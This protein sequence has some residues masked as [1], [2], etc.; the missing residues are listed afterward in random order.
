MISAIER[1]CER[2]RF[3]SLFPDILNEDR[4]VD[5][6]ECFQT[7]EGHSGCVNTLRW[8][9]T[10]TILASGSDDRTVKLWRA[11]EEKHSLDTGHEGNVFAVEFLPSS[12]DRK[13]V[14][15]AADHVVFLHDIETNTNRKW[16]VEGRV[17]RIC[18]LEHDPT[19]WW[20][21]VED[22]KG[23]HQFDTRLEEPEAIIQGPETNG[24]VRDVKSVAVSEAKPHLI[25]VGFD[26][27]AV[28][29]YDRRNFEAPVLTFNPLYTSPLDYHATHVAFNK[30]GTEVVVNHGCGGGVYVFSVNSSEDPKVMERFHAVLDQ[31]REP[32]I[33][34]QALPHADLREI[35][36]SAI[37]GKQFNQAIDY[38]SD[39]IH[40]N[41]P[42]RAFRSVCHSNRA[43]AMLLRRHRGDTY[44]CIRDCVKALEI[45]RG[46]SKALFRLVKSFTTMEEADLARK[47]IQKFKEWF[48]GDKSG[49]M[50]KMENEVNQITNGENHET[51]PVEGTVDYQQR[52]CGSTN[53]QTDIK[54]ANFFGSRDQYIVAGSDCGHM[55]IWNR[56]TSKLQGIWRADDHIL[57]I[58]Q[59][60]PNQF[61][62]AS[63]GIDD[64]IVLW[65]PLLDRSDDYE[66]RHISDPFEFIEKRR[67]ERFGA[68]FQLSLLRDIT[69]REGQ[70]VQS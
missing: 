14:T 20:A 42:E 37:R 55:Y 35:G 43:T 49:M 30:E 56:D 16:E 51:E 69:R 6:L 10:G 27:T 45:H 23:V 36:S 7:L 26:E 24:E 68:G 2:L 70:C 44:A 18:T 11:G 9:K 1:K 59:P 13:L 29:L 57:N 61:M 25:V 34:S 39:L 64:D 33:S 4:L 40:R 41:D 50:T 22:P 3:G 32:V 60:H 46:N 65:Q 58:V 63:S 38:Y 54:E 17:K 12:D 67:E 31:P 53:H 5:S 52:F 15:G 21:A 47:C 28:R 48:P 19:L 66:S 62:L 8:N